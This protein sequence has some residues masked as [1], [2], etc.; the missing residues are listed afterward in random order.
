MLHDYWFMRTLHIFWTQAPCQIYAL[1]ILSP[2]CGFSFP[3]LDK[4]MI[5][6]WIKSNVS[7]LKTDHAFAIVSKN[8]LQH[9]RS[10]RFSSPVHS[11]NFINVGCTVSFMFYFELNFV[12]SVK[13][14]SSFSSSFFGVCMTN[15]Y[16]L[17]R[18]YI[19]HWVV[20]APLSKISSLHLS[21]PGLHSVPLIYGTILLP[22][23]CVSITVAL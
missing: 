3:S 10:Q 16:T 14:P 5:L 22:I 18:L 23:L 13:Y 7:F 19:L 1:K 4:W 11:R 12:Q 8:S 20:L 17:E 21:I 6:I 15:S 9:S 2:V